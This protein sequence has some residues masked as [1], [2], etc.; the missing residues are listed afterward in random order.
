[1]WVRA[2]SLTSVQPEPVSYDHIEW[3]ADPE[4]YRRAAG[5]FTTGVT[6]VTTHVDGVDHAMTVNAFTSVS[7]EPLR[8]LFCAEKIARFHESVLR[9]G[10]WAVSVLSQDGEEAS[11]WFATRGR[12]LAG[13]LDRWK[14]SAGPRTSAPV[15][16]DALAVMECR[17]HAVYD[18][19]D[20]NIVLGDVLDVAAPNPG[21]APL[22][23][24]QGGYAGLR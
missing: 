11:R 5:C 17:T 15:L 19:G 21:S 22:L 2:G 13:Q 12:P 23:Y 3:S 18:G 14:H 16:A 7:L 24:Y 9:A 4:A 6:I 20:H 8:V 1:M 10:S